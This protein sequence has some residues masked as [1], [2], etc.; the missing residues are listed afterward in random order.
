MRVIVPM[1]GLGK[2]MRP[3]TLTTPK[4]LISIAGKPIV[5]RLVEYLSEMCDDKIEHI[6]F[7]VGDFGREVEMNL[8][9]IAENLGAVGSIH[10]QD[11][12][13]GTAHAIL[14]AEEHLKDHVIIAFADTLFYADF[15]VN[16][17]ADGVIWVQKV[18]N[19]QQFGVI[20]VS[21]EGHISE[22]IEKSQ[23]FVSDLAIIGIYYFRDGENLKKE[24]QYLLD[25]DIKEKGEY[26]LTT[27]MEHM[28][29][30]GLKLFP[31]EVKQW[32]DCGNK[33][34]TVDTNRQ[35]LEHHKNEPLIDSSSIIENSTIIPPSYIGPE[36]IIRNSVIGPHVSIGE[37]SIVESCVLSNSIVQKHSFIKNRLI[38]NSMVGSYVLLK[39][40]PQDISIGDYCTDI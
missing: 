1:A 12:P 4:P 18:E 27:A 35:V 13:L 20:K 10:Y 34:A 25:N 9:T 3:H 21:E 26:Q 38:N 2:R 23:V 24:L 39:G 37:K 40:Q 30:K 33:D 32:L 17:A 28:K 7:I 5:Q 36:A 15:K 19:P 31:G 6:A 29:N 22:F 16:E 11:V 14:C 8:L